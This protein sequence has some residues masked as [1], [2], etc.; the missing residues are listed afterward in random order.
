MNTQRQA[1]TGLAVEVRD[2]HKEYPGREGPV[3]AVR[4][5]DLEIPVGECFG[6]LGPNGAGKTSTIEILEGL[7]QP[8][9]GEVRVLGRDWREEPDAIRQRMGVTLQETRFPEKATV[10]ELVTLFR[11]FYAQGQEPSAVLERVS[12]ESKAGS[13]V[14]TLSGGQQR[15]LA[16]AVALVGD[17]ELLF[18]D[19]PTTGLDPQ[20]RR[21]L[22]DVIKH[23]QGQGRTT[24]LTTHYM[25]EA[26]R[27]CDRVAIVD[28][29]KI[30]ALG[31]PAQLIARLG[32]EHVV[33]FGFVDDGRPMW[34][35]EHFA[36]LP[37][38][39]AS[40]QEG[41]GYALTVTEPHRAIPALLDHL[42]GEHRH[43]AR[44]TTRQ[45]S[46]EDVFVSLT[47]RHLRDDEPEAGGEGAKNGR[48]KRRRRGGGMG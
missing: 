25:D 30:I 13:Y 1:T 43:L 7:S 44:L 18:L 31:S 32:G 48:R 39:Q 19:E 20:S 28:Q 14:E 34:P 27:L 11:S 16:V 42:E 6:L 36:R 29:G 17:P 23:L 22:W 21:Q 8:T 2:L 35:A 33:E 38:V 37:S 10:R 40:R 47:G 24:L 41:D 3:Y 26:E 12:L 5:L 15:R 46:L 4:G 45:V 9:S